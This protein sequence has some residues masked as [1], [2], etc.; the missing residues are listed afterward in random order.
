MKTAVRLIAV[1]LCFYLAACAHQA[2]QHVRPMH[3]PTPNPT[4]TASAAD[5]PPASAP[6]ATNPGVTQANIGS[7][8]CVKGWTATIRPPASYTSDL[9]RRQMA[10]L[11]LPGI[12]ADYEEDH[13]VPLEVGGNPT[14]EANLYPE[15]WNG[16]HGAHAKDVIENRVHADVCAGLLSLAQSQHIFLNDFWGAS[17]P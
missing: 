7:T 9:K 3:S 2:M 12:A 14:S 4:I 16:P 1:A 13:R 5:L 17:V 10:A 15:P 11:G 8:I 6:G